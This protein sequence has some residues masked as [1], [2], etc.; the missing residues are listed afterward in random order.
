MYINKTEIKITEH[1]N[2]IIYVAILLS[3]ILTL[4]KWKE[5][6]GIGGLHWFLL[7]PFPYPS[8]VNVFCT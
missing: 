3:C 4:G 1:N 8:P 2:K 7:L 5:I 6:E